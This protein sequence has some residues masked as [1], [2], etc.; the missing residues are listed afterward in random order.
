[1][2]FT[3]EEFI[4][5]QKVIA[6]YFLN[7]LETDKLPQAILLYGEE[8][9]PLKEVG[10]YISQSIY[11]ESK[12]LACNTCQSCQRFLNGN[13][14]DFT[15]LD[16]KNALI[17]KG[18]IDQ[19]ATFYSMSNL[20]DNKKST[21]IINRI[22]NITEDALNAL[23]KFLEEPNSDVLAIITTTNRHKVLPTILSRCQMFQVQAKDPILSVDNYKGEIP[24][25]RYYYLSNLAYSDKEK[26]EINNSSEFDFAYKSV[27]NYL[28]AIYK[29]KENS[30][31]S[32][33]VDIV[34]PFK[35]VSKKSGFNNNKCYNYFY[36]ML[37]ISFKDAVLEKD[38]PLKQI[39]SKLAK[40]KINLARAI[41]FL[42]D[43]DFKL[44]ANLNFTLILAKLGK[45]I[46]E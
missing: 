21:Y 28:E 30:S 14:P 45:I 20:E 11:C 24:L 31:L 19:L 25:D 8:N 44:Q 32:L 43:M 1:M 6:K 34:D 41:S 37:S 18:D 38:N 2:F 46:E 23:L 33:F 5:D 35:Q 12:S 16:G 10:M 15:L 40:Y 17:K 29:S 7:A 9:A 22:E 26:E 27:I 39:T 4:K 3:K 42:M 13:H 36:S